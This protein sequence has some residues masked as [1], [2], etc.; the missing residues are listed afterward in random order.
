L[1]RDGMLAVCQW[2]ER[3]RKQG[4]AAGQEKGK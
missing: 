2:R 1:M 4:A 3:E